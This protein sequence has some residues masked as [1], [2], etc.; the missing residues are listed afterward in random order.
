M[1]QAF[2]RLGSAVT[3]LAGD[4]GLL[5]REDADVS[6]ALA[7]VFAREGIA[8]VASK[9]ARVERDGASICVH[10]A[11]KGGAGRV[12]GDQSWGHTSRAM[13]KRPRSLLAES[14]KSTGSGVCYTP[15][16]ERP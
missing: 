10:Y 5:P 8:A 13:R 16:R 15:V 11:G 1:A 4:R 7:M 12:R 9:L 3:V 2:R 14:M 6:A